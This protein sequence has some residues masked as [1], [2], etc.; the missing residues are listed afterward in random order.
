MIRST[1]SSSLKSAGGSDGNDCDLDGAE[2]AAAPPQR[3]PP[4]VVEMLLQEFLILR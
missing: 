1:D 3:R 4:P 2:A